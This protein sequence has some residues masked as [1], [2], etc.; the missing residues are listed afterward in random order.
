[1]YVC[2]PIG[3]YRR[4]IFFEEFF[5]DFFFNLF[6]FSVSSLIV[7]FLVELLCVSLTAWF[8]LVYRLVSC[9]DCCVCK[10][11]KEV[12]F[13]P[14]AWSIFFSSL[15]HSID[16]NEPYELKLIVRTSDVAHLKFVEW[17]WNFFFSRSRNAWKK[18]SSMQRHSIL[19]VTY[20]NDLLGERLFLIGKKKLLFWPHSNEYRK[21]GQRQEE[22]ETSTHEI[23]LNWR[24]A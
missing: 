13:R 8:V 23:A 12:F 11:I 6:F 18:A 21:T 14:N 19:N 10:G 7:L 20:T 15:C 5:C 16:A 22:E 24:R 2:D 9:I 1:M 4:F 17:S 3:I